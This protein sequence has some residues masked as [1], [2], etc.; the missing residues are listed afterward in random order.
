MTTLLLLKSGYL[1]IPYCSLES[2][3]E[4]N[5]EGYYSALRKTQSTLQTSPDFFPWLFFFFKCLLK[6][7][8][9]LSQK[10][11][12]EVL[13]SLHLP[14]ASL[15]ILEL[16]KTHGKLSIGEITE[17][18][19]L[20]RNTLKKHLQTLVQEQKIFAHGKGKGTWYTIL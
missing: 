8:T 17:L 10:I 15:A 1:Y 9:I 11:D 14:R 7:K 5:K 16:L 19:K 4:E 3:V 12:G 6:Q 20:N 18:S 2:I 13:L